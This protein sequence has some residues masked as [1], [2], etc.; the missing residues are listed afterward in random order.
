[1]N[2]SFSIF[3]ARLDALRIRWSGVIHRPSRGSLREQFTGGILLVLVPAFTFS[4]VVL[5]RL[6]VKEIARMARVQLN[7][8]AELLSY[9]LREWGNANRLMLQA[10]A[11]NPVLRQP[12]LPG[13]TTLLS[14]LQQLYPTRSW[15]FWSAGPEP[16]LMAYSGGVVSAAARSKSEASV[17]SLDYFQE[18][19]RGRTGYGVVRSYLN[20]KACMMIAQPVYPK[21]SSPVDGRAAL[22]G[23][24]PS[25]VLVSCIRL[26]DLAVDTGLKLAL[27]DPALDSLH[28]ASGDFDR[29]KPIRS[30]FVLLGRH[31]NVLYPATNGVEETHSTAA[32]YEKG[33]W[34]PLFRLATQV[35][36]REREFFDSVRVGND[37]YFVLINRADPAWS[38]MLILN[39][40]QALSS[41]HRVLLELIRY[42]VISLVLASLAVYWQCGR[43]IAPI[44]EAG[45]ALQR[46]SE[47]DL[48]T[49]V[50]HARHDEIGHLLDNINHAAVQL[51]LYFMREMAHAV[52]QKQL[53][54]A[55]EI[56]KDF[57]VSRIPASDRLEI[58]PVFLPAYEVGADWYDVLRIEDTFY[59]VVADVCDK[60][61]PSALYMSV[62][63]SL[64]RYGLLAHQPVQGCG[65]DPGERLVQVASRVN[66][67]MATNHGDSMMFATVFMA[68]IDPLKGVL[69]YI[70]AGHE[71][72]IVAGPS[73]LRSLEPTGPALG[74]FPDATFTTNRLDLE[75]GSVLVAYTDGVTDARSP[76][77]EAWGREALLSFMEARM[78]RGQDAADLRDDLVARVQDHMAGAAAFDDFTVMV[79]RRLA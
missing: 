78:G 36:T 23:G 77:D 35:A 52:T 72:P 19:L 63:R 2:A 38:T 9:G 60:G 56:Q 51:Q 4:Y 22:A 33:Y 24:R 32:G 14:S 15:Q 73:G 74:L 27:Q 43:I 17:G 71:M 25:G 61:I 69:H 65:P 10:L 70:S 67:Y 7:A 62:F 75:P 1:M 21:L 16:Q 11:L 13:V 41:L 59:V 54:T 47:G 40:N 49:R 44:R 26:D 46:I 55:R 12:D 57:L 66:D 28:G 18:A 53:E 6:A 31:G 29:D 37:D 50:P 39:H 76:G 34:G 30:A 68:A 5:N 45:R 79:L 58:A 8:E 48:E 20:D 42:G 3:R 64:L